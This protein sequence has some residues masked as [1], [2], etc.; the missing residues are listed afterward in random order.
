MIAL[1]RSE[2]TQGRR[3][4]HGC[5]R[6][7]QRDLPRPLAR[8]CIRE[9]R[10]RLV[11]TLNT[12]KALAKAMKSAWRALPLLGLAAILALSPYITTISHADL[13]SIPS[14]VEVALS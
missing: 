1:S 4:S 6:P 11:V 9:W 8:R 13:P 5:R 3:P 7:F 14:S 2:A 12:L 10:C